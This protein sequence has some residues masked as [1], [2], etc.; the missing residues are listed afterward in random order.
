MAQ[1]Y[2]SPWHK[3]Y[4]ATIAYKTIVKE[5]AFFFFLVKQNTNNMTH[6]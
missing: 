3:G 2:L 4:Y 6:A 5:A 1:N